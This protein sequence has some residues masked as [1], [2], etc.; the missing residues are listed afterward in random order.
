MSQVVAFRQ[1]Q[2]VH[3]INGTERVGSTNMP[4]RRMQQNTRTPLRQIQIYSRGD[5][6]QRRASPYA[7]RRDGATRRLLEDGAGRM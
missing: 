1:A 2:A 7:A 5:R 4:S 6:N 3:A